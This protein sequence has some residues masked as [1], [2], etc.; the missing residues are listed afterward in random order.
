M[1]KTFRHIELKASDIQEE[2]N[3]FDDA[4]L[5]LISRIYSHEQGLSE[6]L[7]NAVD[8]YLRENIPDEKKLVVFQFIDKKIKKPV[9]ECIDFIGI[10]KKDII[11]RFK[12]WGDVK[13]AQG[14]LKEVK[15]F[16]GHGTGGK[17]YMR[18]WFNES[19]LISYKSGKLNIFGFKP[20]KKYGFLKGYE[21]KEVTPEF[22][23]RFA[24]IENN[25]FLKNIEQGI[26]NGEKGFTVVRGVE[27]R[28]VKNE[29]N[30]KRICEQFKNH[31]QALRILNRIKAPVIYNGETVYDRLIPDKIKAKPGFEKPLV[32]LNQKLNSKLILHTSEIALERG[33]RLG[34]LNRIDIVGELGVLASYSVLE[35]GV[36]TFPQAAFIYGECECPAMEKHTQLLR[37]KLEDNSETRALLEWIR[38]Q[39]DLFASS[40]AEEEKIKQEELEREIASNY[41]EYLNKWKNKFMPRIFG[42]LLG[43]LSGRGKGG[44]RGKKKKKLEIPPHGFDF[45]SP[46]AK[47]PLNVESPLTLKILTEK[48]PL[49]SLITASSDEPDIEIVNP[50]IV[51]NPNEVKTVNGKETAVV[52]FYTLGKSLEAVGTVIAQTG[53]LT[54]PPVKVEVIEGIG[55]G[56]SGNYPRVLLSGL[57]DDPLDPGKKVILEPR[58]P[59]VYQR[60]QDFKK[61]IYWINTVSPLAQAVLKKRGTNSIEWRNYLFQRYID[62]FAKEALYKLEKEHGG[63][64]GASLVDR[65]I[66]DSL[67]SKIHE[68]GTKDLELF[69]FNDKYEPELPETKNQ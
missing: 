33:G 63:S 11:E 53:E 13:A 44:I 2:S 25:P 36:S 31:P 39:I 64:L 54:T 22:A 43:S 42:E 30:V 24:N 20:N 18:D 67:V 21:D 56:K 3:V 7:K 40:V 65:I 8:A 46:I 15:T 16:G 1:K 69:L 5:D 68:A 45:S 34:D 9:I 12:R 49:G 41:N 59:V 38:E 37:G 61:G 50:Q 4:L 48:I 35:L 57:D 28:G 6:W 60:P 29:I 62:I 14:K 58:H 27:P 26:V 51:L 17:F 52:N 55:S 19:Y 66:F 23:I 10:D 32:F 47:I